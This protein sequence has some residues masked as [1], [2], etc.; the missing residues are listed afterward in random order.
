MSVGLLLVTRYG[1]NDE[2]LKTATAILSPMAT[3]VAGRTGLYHHWLLDDE[4]SG[5]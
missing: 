4:D 3:Q 1:I 5:A 2:L